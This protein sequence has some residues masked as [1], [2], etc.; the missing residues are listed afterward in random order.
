MDRKV[1]TQPTQACRLCGR[2]LVVQP[3]GRGFPPAITERKLRKQCQAAGC[4]CE[5]RY[6]AGITFGPRAHGMSE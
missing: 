1:M 4:P 5:P 3:D 2:S 6:Q